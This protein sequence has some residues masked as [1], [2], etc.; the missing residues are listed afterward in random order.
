M[1]WTRTTSSTR[2]KPRG[3]PNQSLQEIAGG[4]QPGLAICAINAGGE[5]GKPSG[6]SRVF[7]LCKDVSL[8]RLVLGGGPQG[9]APAG[10]LY[11]LPGLRQ[12]RTLPL[13]QAETPG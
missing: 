4:A 6:L 3:V 12:G 11:L 1:R 13:T 8:E 2:C 7:G 5:V 9:D 10:R